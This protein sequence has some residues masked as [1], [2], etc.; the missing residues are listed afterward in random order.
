M[1]MLLLYKNSGIPVG[2]LIPVLQ[3]VNG[4]PELTDSFKNIYAHT[5][6]SRAGFFG[7]GAF[8][9]EKSGTFFTAGAVT[10]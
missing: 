10:H 2:S 5:V 4:K 3:R 9:P 8:A 7:V 6:K 1:G